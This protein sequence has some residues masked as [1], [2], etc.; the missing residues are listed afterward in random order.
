MVINEKVPNTVFLTNK[1]VKDGASIE[2]AQTILN[3][4][5]LTLKSYDSKI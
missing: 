4:K 2:L 1:K 5:M 3:Q